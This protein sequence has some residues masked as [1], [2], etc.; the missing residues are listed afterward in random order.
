MGSGV[1]QPQLGSGP[2]ANWTQINPEMV[3]ERNVGFGPLYTWEDIT[4][5]L[6]RRRNAQ[7]LRPTFEPRADFEGIHGGPHMHV[8]GSMARLNTA[9]RDPIFYMHHA[10]VDMLWQEFRNRQIRL[11]IDPATD[12][13]FNAT[14][15]R[16]RP[17]HAPGATMGFF[18]RN[19]FEVQFRQIDGL[20]MFFDRY[21]RYA[22]IPSCTRFRTDCGSPYLFCETNGRPR[23]VSRTVRDVQGLVDAFPV[24]PVEAAGTAEPRG[25]A[26][27]VRRSPLGIANPF[28]SQ[29]HVQSSQTCPAPQPVN[30]FMLR[31]NSN[32][33]KLTANYWVKIPTRIITKRPPQYH[34]FTDYSLYDYYSQ[35]RNRIGGAKRNFIEPGGQHMYRECSRKLQTVGTIKVVSYGLNYDASAEEY[36]LADNRLGISDTTSFIPVKRPSPGAPSEAIIAAFDSCGRV[37]K[38]YYLKSMQGSGMTSDMQQ[39]GGGIHVTTNT[40]LQYGESFAEATLSSWQIKGP[41]SCPTYDHANAPI[42]FFCDYTEDWFWPT[43]DGHQTIIQQE[44]TGQDMLPSIPSIPASVLESESK[45][46]KRRTKLRRKSKKSRKQSKRKSKST[47]SAIIPPSPN[48][49]VYPHIT[50]SVLQGGVFLRYRDPFRESQ[51][52]DVRFGPMIGKSK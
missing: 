16:F 40:P 29:T 47:I 19:V 35:G 14:D 4:E 32:G 39:I 52:A 26:A 34:H 1:G 36:A 17:Q 49:A 12:Y 23:C 8:G 43:G 18:R 31:E 22:P 50:S 27:R 21:I 30:D 45:V 33:V 24:Q 13:P 20:S 10:F 2:F 48:P 25:P 9:A 51:G 15:R 7:I 42:T 44:R 46:P 38:S 11:G 37:C 41:N 28:L 3:F 6:R 5:I